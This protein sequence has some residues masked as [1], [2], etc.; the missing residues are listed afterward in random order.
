MRIT[1]HIFDAFLK[2]ATKCHLR[3]LGE[4]GSGNEYAEWVRAQ[5]ESYQREAARRLQEAVPE[6]ERVVASHASENLKAAKWRLGVDLLAQTPDR[7]ADSHVHESQPNEEKG[8]LAGPCSERLLESR[9]HTVERVPSEGRGKPAQ[10][11]PI[12]FVFRNKLT[13]DD[14]LLLAFDALVLS[15]VLGR[16][17]SLG[18]I[19]HGD[20]H[21]TLK[22]K[23]SALAGVVWKRIEKI[24]VLL[25]NPVPP[26]LVLN[27]HCAECEFQAR[28]RQKALE[29]DDLSL[30]AGMSEKER[31]RHRSKG[32]FSVTQLSYTFRPRRTP[33]GA[34]HLA[35]PHHLALQA[36]AIR[37]N[38][39]YVHG[40]PQL[41][42][43]A[44]RIY[45][46]IEGLP[47]S[48]FHYLIGTLFVSEGQETFRAF[49]ADEES[50]EPGIFTQ[51]VEAV[52]LVPLFR[53]LHFGAYE[54]V[55]LKRM[56]AKMPEH[57][58]PKIDFILEHA[59]NVLSVIHPHVYFPTYSN[60]LKD[61]GRFLRYKRTTESATGLQSIVW[62]TNWEKSGDSKLKT[63][64]ISYNEDDCR[65]LKCLCELMG[66][67]S[68][69]I[70]KIAESAPNSFK[71]QRTDEMKKGRARWEIFAPKKYALEDLKVINKCAYFD[72]QRERILVRTHPHLKTINKRRGHVK[73]DVLPPNRVI[74]FTRNRCASCGSRKLEQHEGKKH[75]CIDL[76]F[77]KAIVR[78]WI[79]RFQS[80]RYTCMRCGHEFNSESQFPDNTRK[81]GLGLISWAV[82]F[83]VVRGVNMLSVQKTLSDLFTISIPSCQLYKFKEGLK[84]NYEVLYDEILR[85]I[86]KGP[87]LH[88]DET[89]ANLHGQTG[90]VWVMATVDKVYYFYKPSR[91]GSFLQDL[92]APFSGVLVSDFFTAYDSLSCQQQKC[93]AHLVRDIDDDLLRNPLDGEL[94]TI[95]QE[96]GV[97][98]R[99]IIQTIDQY[100]LKKRHLHKHK[101]SVA[102]FLKQV[103]AQE[104]S[105]EFAVKYQ[106]RFEKSGPKMFTFLDH[107]GVPWNNTN[108]EHAIKRFAKYRK[109]TDGYFTE[110]SLKEYL[111]LASVLET[112]EFNNVNV[113]KFLLSKEMTLEGLLRMSGRKRQSHT[114]LP[115][116]ASHAIGSSA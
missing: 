104:F 58:H 95:A 105:S 67:M 42:E 34:K 71:V 55:A 31:N 66:K 84:A 60:G 26:D 36:L 112:C 73:V 25:S 7:R 27:R 91:E 107:D 79:T 101:K 86:L 38:T 77:S 90:Y 88:I 50:D 10:F 23:T 2:C 89:T 28:C 108:A 18:K 115:A 40:N 29:K 30:L 49:W 51:F 13:K 15:Q 87:L 33:K 110:R 20:D 12:R 96:L 80:F 32:I 46:D 109:N 92:L 70:S 4:I 11:I 22:V 83:N 44:T 85:D 113:L 116:D 47:D 63:S 81:Y 103:N 39:V 75:M 52:C 68:T 8:G 93:L 45:L 102:R 48:E 17:V 94:R 74:R 53:V 114:S 97:I 3:S 98:L 21:A 59:T 76:R 100:G 61:I 54:T 14:R 19:I 72:Y 37:E 64:L 78:R 43:S 24:A 5:D 1:P 99:T 57:L 6:T 65:T 62:R 56:K 111:I 106:K 82:Y 16:E 35:K 69:G 9:L 41:P